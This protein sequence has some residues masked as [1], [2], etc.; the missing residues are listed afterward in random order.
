MTPR[1]VKKRLTV[2]E[3]P[4]SKACNDTWVAY[5]K[6][7]SDKTFNAGYKAAKAC[8]GCRAEEKR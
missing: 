4:H 7:P 3:M 8:P 2:G 6:K 5:T 1:T